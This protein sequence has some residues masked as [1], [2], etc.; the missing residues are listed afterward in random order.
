M[1]GFVFTSNYQVA[2]VGGA[3]IGRTASSN[4]LVVSD[5]ERGGNATLLCLYPAIRINTGV[6]IVL[7]DYAITFT[8]VILVV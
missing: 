6:T 8:R 7:S 2:A 5:I 3:F 4:F 1:N